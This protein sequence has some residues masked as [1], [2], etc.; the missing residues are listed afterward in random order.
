MWVCGDHDFDSIIGNANIEFRLA[1]LDPFGNC[2]NGIDRIYTH[3][4]NQADDYSKINIWNRSNYLNIWVV[5]S[6]G[7]SGVAGYAYYPSAVDA[8]MLAG[9]DGIVILHNYIVKMIM[10]HLHIQE[11]FHRWYRLAVTECLEVI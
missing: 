7:E 4:T 10:I 1:Q 2:T 6:I 11:H 8:P 5:K 3:K 9:I